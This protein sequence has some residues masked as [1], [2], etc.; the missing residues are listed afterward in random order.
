MPED[1]GIGTPD[2]AVVKRGDLYIP[3]ATRFIILER[4]VERMERRVTYL[5][6]LLVVDIVIS[7]AG[8]NGSP[9]L[10]DFIKIIFRQ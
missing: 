9:I 5:T 4:K 8:V 1:E 6:W 10:L 7:L 2:V 3:L